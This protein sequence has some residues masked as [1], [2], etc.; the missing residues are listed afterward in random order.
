MARASLRNIKLTPLGWIL[1]A[2]ALLGLV[3]SLVVFAVSTF[4]STRIRGDYKTELQETYTWDGGTLV[5]KNIDT[6]PVTCQAVPESGEQRPL[7]GISRQPTNKSFLRGDRYQEFEPWFAGSAK[8][9]CDGDVNAWTGS[10]ASL[11]ML[12]QSG[13]LRLGGTGVV[14]VLLL[15]ALVFCRKR[16]GRE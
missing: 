12:T 16:P 5:V 8:V 13:L 10:S 2:I 4:S 14:V 11:Y 1:V 9:T 3:A 6:R 7:E 15:A